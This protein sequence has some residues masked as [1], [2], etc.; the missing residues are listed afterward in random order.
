MN[1]T[2]KIIL[3]FLSEQFSLLDIQVRYMLLNIVY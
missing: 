1:M 3:L 2:I